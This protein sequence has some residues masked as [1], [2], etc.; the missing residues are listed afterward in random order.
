M[1]KKTK[2]PKKSTRERYS[3]ERAELYFRKASGST[4]PIMF[5]FAVVAFL[6]ARWKHGGAPFYYAV[7]VAFAAIAVW[8]IFYVR[9]TKVGPEEVDERLTHIRDSIDLETDALN[10]S[11]LDYDLF[12]EADKTVLWGY[13]TLPIQD[14]QPLLRADAADDIARSSHLQFTCFTITKF[15]LEAFSSVRSLM[16]EEK[17]ETVM[18]WPIRHIR[19]ISIDRNGEHCPLE[20]GSEERALRRFSVLSVRGSSRR[21]DRSY[22]ICEDCRE[23]AEALIAK[24]QQRQAYLEKGN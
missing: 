19:D 7:A 18:E 2:Q 1:A 5:A 23:Q 21:D 22:A 12:M 9:E 10:A 14:E 8:Q 16:N 4:V 6:F 15:S 17:E 13:S 20:A 24:I 11:D 3:I